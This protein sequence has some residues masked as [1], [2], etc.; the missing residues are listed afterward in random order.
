MV[1]ILC[2]RRDIQLNMG[3][4]LFDRGHYLKGGPKL[5]IN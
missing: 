2:Y 5:S 4:Q 1:L 3:T